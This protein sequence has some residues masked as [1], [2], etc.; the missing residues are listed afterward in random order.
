MPTTQEDTLSKDLDNLKVNNGEEEEEDDEPETS[1]DPATAAKKKKK[2]RTKKKKP[3][4]TTEES[5]NG[6]A[7]GA[8]DAN[9]AANTK[10]TDGAVKPAASS[11]SKKKQAGGAKVQ[12]DPPSV[13]ISELFP[14]GDFPVGQI[15]EHPKVKDQDG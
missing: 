8:I 9:A 7:N 3:A 2:R 10:P 6:Q 5:E 11:P 12:T 4:A 13:P 15:M 14:R 1:G